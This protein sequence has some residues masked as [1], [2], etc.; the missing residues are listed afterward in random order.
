[1]GLFYE[2]GVR[3]PGLRVR[4]NEG[5]LPKGA[6]IIMINE[7]PL[8]MGT[9][10]QAKILVN[11]TAERLRLLNI[12]GEPATNPANGND[13]AWVSVEHQN[14]CEQAGLTTWDASGYMVLHL[15]AVLRK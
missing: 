3:Y 8:V 14:L 1:D 6:Y 2:L 7:I 5:D 9:V 10:D 11:D 12:P 13:C 4:G 15:S